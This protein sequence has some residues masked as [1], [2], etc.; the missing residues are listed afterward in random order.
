[1]PTWTKMSFQNSNSPM[2]EHLTFFHDHSMIILVSVT[3]MTMYL[4]MSSMLV[5]SFNRFFLEAQEVELFWTTVPSMMLIFIAMPSLK[6][7]YMM[8]ENI[9]PVLTIKTMGFQWYWAYEYSEFESLKFNSM[10]TKNKMMRLMET[11]N[12]LIIP[13]KT[14]TQMLITSK[15]VIHSWT[16]PSLG[17]K[18]DAIPG[19]LNQSSILINRPS[20]MV[21]Q[22]SEICGAGHSFMPI[23]LEA[24]AMKKFKALVSLSG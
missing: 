13:M 23:T 4:M 16:M 15:D 3:V 12:H 18:M 2:M 24:P 21:G 7:L 6:T 17:L 10:L 1:M 20:L 8:E 11:S 19:R 22:C 14:P 9:N 5:K